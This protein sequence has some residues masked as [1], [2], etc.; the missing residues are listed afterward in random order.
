MNFL[1]LPLVFL[2][3]VGSALIA[4]SRGRNP[5]PWFFLGLITGPLALVFVVLLRAPDTPH[6]SIS[7][8]GARVFLI[9]GVG[10]TIVA[11]TGAVMATLRY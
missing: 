5:T 4:Y 1:W 10:L 7:E 11:V 2:V 6:R 9:A 3:P 8:P